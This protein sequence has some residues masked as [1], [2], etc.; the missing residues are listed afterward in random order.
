MT[1]SLKIL[2][3]EDDTDD[4][5]ITRDLLD[6]IEGYAFDL[7]WEHTHARGLRR[8]QET[9][10]DLCLVDYR[11]GAATG[12]DFISEAKTH[13][14]DIPLI[15]V[16]GVSDHAVDVEASEAGASDFVE[17]ASLTAVS[18]ER[19]IRYS[20]ARMQQNRLRRV[21]ARMERSNL[22][23]ELR[24]AIAERQFEVYLQPEVNCETRKVTKAEALVRWNHPERGLL[25]P[26]HFIDCAEKSDLIVGIGKC[27][28]DQV[29][30]LSN[31]LNAITPEVT[32]AFNVSV[33]QMERHDFAYTVEQALVANRT[34]PATIE[35]EITESV[36]MREPR[37]VRAHLDA[38]KSF[39]VRFTLDDFGTGYSGLAT[40]KDFPFDSIKVDRAFVQTAQNSARN[41]AIA[42]TI[43]YLAD[44]MHLETV[45]EG[46]ETEDH[47][48][49]VKNYGATYAQGFL[50]SQALPFEAFQK[51][52]HKANWD[53]ETREL[54]VAV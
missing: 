34:D 35:I 45:A 8:I 38:L 16:T 21:H 18:L 53:G 33:A 51:Y 15:L 54:G 44:V 7:E 27:V 30:E 25:M 46:V 2:L 52:L 6:A 50:F 47:F 48:S 28:I 17:K 14:P 20:I 26:G 41:R 42:K 1:V 19:A 9:Q 37:Q 4:Y 10:F 36:A 5:L 43:F 29:C 23:H 3:V 11:I 24:Q 13:D 39:G 49:F 40:L 31:R 22:E 12:I 32:I